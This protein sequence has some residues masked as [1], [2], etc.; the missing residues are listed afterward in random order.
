MMEGPDV[1]AV[2]ER[3][4]AL[5]YLHA[6]THDTFGDDTLAAVTAFQTANGLEADGV[7]GPDTWAALFG[8]VGTGA[9]AEPERPAAPDAPAYTRLLRRLSTGA[10]VMAVKE[11]LVALGYL[12]AATHDTFGDDTLAAVTAFQAANGLEADGVVGQDTWAAA[13]WR[14]KARGAGG[15]VGHPGKHRHGGGAGHRGRAV[16]RGRHAAQ[17]RP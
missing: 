12:H 5:G 4:V 16:R 14:C 8:G 13:V 15:R 2:K 3:L 10:D 1:M 9:P 7:V 11:R 17:D 6:A